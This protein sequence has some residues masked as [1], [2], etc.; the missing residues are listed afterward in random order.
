MGYIPECREAGHDPLMMAPRPAIATFAPELIDEILDHLLVALKAS[1]TAHKV[2]S[3]VSSY[4]L[5]SRAW[6]GPVQRRTMRRLVVKTEEQAERVTSE[7]VA[8]GLNWHVKTLRLGCHKQPWK[9]WHYSPLA[10]EPTAPGANCIS[11]R[12]NFLALLPL[13]PNATRL[14]LDPPFTRFRISDHITI[15]TLPPF[16]QLTS[17]IVETRRGHHDIELIRSILLL[18]PNLTHLALISHEK[19]FVLH[20]L[21]HRKYPAVLPH[22]RT[23]D[24]KGGPLASDFVNL[25]LLSDSTLKRIE[26][27]KWKASGYHPESIR[28]LLKI[29]APKLRTL[30]YTAFKHLD[31]LEGHLVPVLQRCQSLQ[32]MRLQLREAIAGLLYCLPRTLETIVVPSVEQ[33]HWLLKELTLPPAGLKNVVIDGDFIWTRGWGLVDES[34]LLVEVVD[35]CKRG[36]IV[37]IATGEE[38]KKNLEGRDSLI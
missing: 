23:L 36:G 5:I 14:H 20:T 38:L 12:D 11:P 18:T 19:F 22:L 26:N 31:P 28:S 10:K 8:R 37:L 7:L 25:H 9:S 6:R 3:P 2:S 30:D 4:A 16:P 35:A 1:P 29:I 15:L 27:F 17:L 24:L 32:S 34:V 33:A 13:F 21:S